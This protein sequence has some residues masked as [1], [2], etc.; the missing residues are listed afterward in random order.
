LKAENKDALK[1]LQKLERDAAKPKATVADKQAARD[2]RRALQSYFDETNRLDAD[3]EPYRQIKA[4]LAAAR[5][6]YRELMKNFVLVL[7]QRCTGMT[8]EEK[9]SLVL[10][11]LLAELQAGLRTALSALRQSL[12]AFFETLWG[13]YRVPLTA[14]QQDRDAN[15]GK[16]GGILNRLGYAQGTGP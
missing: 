6:T 16:L 8:A 15:A 7:K 14:L 3:L 9:Q 12:I 13:K 11:L 2:A 1:E 4:E 5:S 10:E